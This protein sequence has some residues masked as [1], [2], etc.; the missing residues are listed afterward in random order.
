MLYFRTQL[1][2]MD[3]TA[4]QLGPTCTRLCCTHYAWIS[5]TAV[6]LYCSPVAVHLFSKLVL[7]YTKPNLSNPAVDNL[8]QWFTH[9]SSRVSNLR[10]SQLHPPKL[11]PSHTDQSQGSLTHRHTHRKSISR[12]RSALRL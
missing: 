4:V 11:R 5:C 6:Y 8:N 1:L 10:L 9:V 12:N 2:Q 7:T 3:C